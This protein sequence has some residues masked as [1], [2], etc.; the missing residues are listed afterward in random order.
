MEE[1]VWI[2]PAAILN[3]AQLALLSEGDPSVQAVWKRALEEITVQAKRSGSIV[4]S[5]LQFS[6]DEPTEKRRG[7]VSEVIEHAYELTRSYA[8]ERDAMIE[9][10]DCQ[11]SG[12]V[13][14]SAI[15]IE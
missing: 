10:E 6:R 4:R 13:L 7:D 1:G 9:F 14:M 2:P 12:W 11:R 8:L 3:G 5:I 15:E